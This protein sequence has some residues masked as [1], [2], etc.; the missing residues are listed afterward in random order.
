MPPNQDI[1]RTVDAFLD[2]RPRAAQLT[3]MRQALQRRLEGL[4]SALGRA[5][6]SEERERLGKEIAQLR[7]QVEAIAREEL[8]TEFVEDSVR[9]TASFSMLRPEDPETDE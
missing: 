9:A 3:K 5:V 7:C 2:G 6:L 4:Q 8:I 1:E